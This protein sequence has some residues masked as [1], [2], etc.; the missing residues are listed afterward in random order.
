MPEKFDP[1]DMDV[2]LSADRKAYLD[3][4]G[5]LSVLP[6]RTHH[7][8]ADIGCGPG[9]LTVPMGKYLFDGKLYAVDIQ[10]EMLDATRKRL[11]AINLTNVE[12][13]LSEEIKLPLDDATLGGAVIA[14]VLQEAN[15]PG[16]LL[17][18]VRR[19]LNETGWLAI[20]EWHKRETDQG[21]PV[22]RRI[23]EDDMRK[24]VE[25]LDFRFRL[26]HTLNEDQYLVL[27]RK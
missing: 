18:E 21:P 5:L 10:Q 9:Y 17:E 24:L 1:S 14:F 7:V 22:E 3:V 11:E 13:M 2:L 20:L 26:R 12:L 4:H 6:V 15:D 27:A 25:K 23:A 16:A 19:C 8:V